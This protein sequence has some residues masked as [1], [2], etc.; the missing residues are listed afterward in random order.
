MRAKNLRAALCAFV[1]VAFP[2]AARV[3]EINVTAVE[4]FAEGASFGETGGYERVK[5]TF[6]G[7]LDPADARNKAIVNLDKA[8]RNAGGRVEY[9]ADFFI[10]RPADAVRGNRKILFDVTNRGRK[11]VHWRL[12]DARLASPAAGNDP[13]TVQDAGNG[14]F[15]RR[16]YTIVWSGWDPDAPRSNNG[17]AMKA[18][19][20]MNHPADG[21][22]IPP[23]EGGE[24]PIVRMI[25]DEL[26]S[27]TRGTPRATFRL[28]H[29]AATLDT[30]QAK[31]TVRRAESDPRREIPASGWEYVN[32]RE[33]R[34]LNH[35][36]A[37]RHPSSSEEG[38]KLGISAPSE[39]GNNSTPIKPEPGSIYE[40]HYPAKNPRVLGIGMA[41][42][43]DLVS[44]LRYE[45]ADSKGNA[46]PA[47]PGIKVALGF[48][49]SQSGRFLRDFVHQGF[50]QDESA[51][52][53]FDGLLAHTAGVGGVFLNYEFGQP[54]RTNTQHDDHTMPE[55]AFPFST[56]RMKD[57]V[58]GKT[59]SLFRDD[60]FDPLWMETNTSTE[61][62]QKGASLLVTDPLGQRDVEHP[63]NARGYLIAGTQ[64]GGAAWMRSTAG[65]CVNPRNPHSPTPALR[66]LLVALDEWASEKRAPP[67]SRMPTLK[68]GTLVMPD[69]LA[70]PEIPGIQVARRMNEIGVLKDWVKPEMDMTR[71]Y[72]PLVTQVDADGNETAGVLLPDIAVPLATYTGWNLYKAPLPEGE[73]C[74][75][76]GTYVPF[77]ATRAEREAK[78]DPRLSIEERYGDHAAYVRKV[79]AAAKQLVGERLL[80][81]EDAER[82]VTQA[83]SAEVAQRF[84]Q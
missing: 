42:A 62:W 60:G 81:A 54:A 22:G 72:R 18:I 26:V 4:P 78:G 38:M 25:R 75:R 1:I 73:L 32:S 10:L 33:I 23:R 64:H 7:E 49:I 76:F 9:E 21:V 53:V 83:K 48:G 55:N 37:S 63:A 74:D 66:A 5:G 35:P 19:V 27:G 39:E 65:P 41:A 36:G 6:K 77:A 46:N 40:L 84:A 61:Y 2:A 45:A 20:A 14:L 58:T 59:G 31:L 68:D 79:E 16:G 44:F 47:H 67:A 29:E 69:K 71:P 43:R 13:R 15:L 51:R 30:A 8:P 82:F 80:L 28:T 34:L 12:M 24:K 17:M 70:F 50:N 11:Y 57:P 52:K 56:A 3:T